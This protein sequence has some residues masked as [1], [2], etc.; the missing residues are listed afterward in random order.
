MVQGLGTQGGNLGTNPP[1]EWI[2]LLEGRFHKYRDRHYSGYKV[3]T[4]SVK[5]KGRG[6]NGYILIT[7]RQNLITKLASNEKRDYSV[8]HGSWRHLQMTAP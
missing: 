1:P 6:W 3:Q 4:R 7:A 8:Y 5:Q 2:E